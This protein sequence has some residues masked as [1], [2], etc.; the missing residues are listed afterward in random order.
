MIKIIEKAKCCGCGACVNVC[1]KQCIE[2]VPDDEGFLYP[3]INEELCIDCGMCIRSCQYI[4]QQYLINTFESPE[5]YAAKS[6]EYSILRKSSS[7]G[8]AHVLSDYIISEHGAVFGAAY[9]DHMKVE[10]ILVETVESATKLQ[11]SKYVQSNIGSTYKETKKLLAKGRK[12]LFTGTPCQ[13]AGLYSFLGVDHENLYTM[14]LICFGVPSPKVF[15]EYLKLEQAK[16]RSRINEINFRDKSLGW[17]IPNTKITFEDTRKNINQPSSY[18]RY[19]QIFISHYATRLSCHNCL[20]TKI[21]RYADVTVGDYWGIDKLQT[22]LEIT[23]G[24]SKILVNTIKGKQLFQEIENRLTFIQMPLE[25][26]LRPNLKRPPL[27]NTNRKQF[28]Q[29]FNNKGLNYCAK[30]YTKSNTTKKIRIKLRDTLDFLGVLEIIK[31]V[32]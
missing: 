16:H 1:P 9:N 25:T 26:A 32:R 14:D 2:M 10:H 18:N 12:V 15:S 24:I 30:K 4:N 21:P 31:K 29:D 7:G 19:Y 8:V 17:Q 23:N 13:I 6:K 20:Y 22:N 27:Q 3:I 5:V 11:G 28:F